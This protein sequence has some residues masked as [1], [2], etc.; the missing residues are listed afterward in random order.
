MSI[1]VNNNIKESERILKKGSFYEIIDTPDSYVLLDKTKRGL[2]PREKSIDKQTG[3]MAEKGMI[4]DV[5][6][7]GHMIPIRWYYKKD[8]CD[9][10]K[11]TSHAK[12]IDKRHMELREI[13][14]PDN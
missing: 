7:I 6:G 12:A 3:T 9:M 2:E 14:C 5:D 1:D 11:V 10:S 13:T 8:A 4:H